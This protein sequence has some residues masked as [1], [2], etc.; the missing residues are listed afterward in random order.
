MVYRR[1]IFTLSL[2]AA[3]GA[4]A[5]LL[6]LAPHIQMIHARDR[7]RDIVARFR[8]QV[9]DAPE[10]RSTAGLVDD[11]PVSRPGSVSDLLDRDVEELAPP[12]A[13]P[14]APATLPPERLAQSVA[15]REYDLAPDA[16][17]LA[18]VDA[19]IL[20]ITE[21]AARP[22]IEVA[23]RLVR[24]GPDAALPEGSAAAL[25][26]PRADADA[27]LGLPTDAL[28]RSLLADAPAGPG[29]TAPSPGSDPLPPLAGA[30]QEP[31]ALLPTLPELPAE[32]LVAASPTE[33]SV[34][35]AREAHDYEFLDD[36]V[37]I[38][39]ETHED[40]SEADGYFRLRILP[41][42]DRELTPLP[43]DVVFVVD[44]SQSIPQHK[45]NTTA[46]AVSRAIERLRPQDQ[47]NVVAFKAGPSNF[48]DAPVSATDEQKSAARAFLRALESGG[49]TDFHRA[50]TPT[51]AQPFRAGLP[52]IVFVVSDGRPTTGL[53]DSRAIILSSTA[54]NRLGHS[55]FGFGG[56]NTV[57]RYLL[58]LLA[59]QNRGAARVAA[60]VAAIE[61][62]L[63]SFFA[64]LDDPLLVGLRTEFGR[65]DTREVYPRAVPDFYRA[66]PITLYGRYARSAPGD[67]TMRLTGQAL[68]Q[69]KELLFR[70]ALD[71]A[72]RG[73]AQI[74][75]EW[76]FAKSYALIGEM[77][78][79]GE[80]PAR[81][82]AIRQLGERYG[83][84]TVYSP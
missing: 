14:P 75:R 70:A 62:D 17:A 73:D 6:W 51:L 46:R 2:L 23:R 37:D 83:V 11:V 26:T 18:R 84:Q 72:A 21:A 53:L 29:I 65:I 9:S 74:A 68:D 35:A 77:A 79:D 39:L 48:R 28:A 12:P 82:D 19:R 45:L 76:A 27:A 49:A 38:Q 24:P 64:V 10:P 1:L 57:N 16:D 7:S 52:A 67:F 42:A 31:A 5:L 69:R 41:R 58:D 60:N 71:T 80:T 30:T 22:N 61:A 44:A 3:L 15:P 50:L 55:I 34:E 20:E 40:P 32:R 25:R 78:I 13:L 8:V 59:Y 56:G 81:L 66:R 36:L 43:K 4:Y 47:F 33:R 63:P 54:E